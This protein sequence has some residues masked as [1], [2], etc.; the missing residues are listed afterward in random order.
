MDG[1]FKGLDKATGEMVWEQEGDGNREAFAAVL[2]VGLARTT[3][4][5]KL[6]GA[7]KGAFDGGLD[8]PH[9]EKRFPGYTA[10]EEGEE[11]SYEPA[12][13]R[14]RIFGAHVDKYMAELKKDD[15]DAYKR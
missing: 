6:F 4:G 9:S 1:N 8:V 11:G 15:M 5:N 2:D 10:G 14:E 7:L 13:H 3:T 12:V